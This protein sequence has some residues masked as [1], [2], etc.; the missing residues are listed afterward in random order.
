MLSLFPLPSSQEKKKIS[1]RAVSDLQ[2]HRVI[3][4]LYAFP[5][6]LTALQWGRVAAAYFQIGGCRETFHGSRIADLDI[7][8]GETG[9]VEIGTADGAFLIALWKK[10]HF[11][12]ICVNLVGVDFSPEMIARANAALRSEARRNPTITAEITFVLVDVRD[13]GTNTAAG[14]AAKTQIMRAAPNGIST[15]VCYDVFALENREQYETYRA[16]LLRLVNVGGRVVWG[17][18]IPQQTY[19]MYLRT[20]PDNTS[21]VLNIVNLGSKALVNDYL[22][23]WRRAARQNH[24]P[25]PVLEW[26][27]MKKHFAE[28]THSTLPSNACMINSRTAVTAD[29]TVVYISSTPL[30]FRDYNAQYFQYFARRAATQAF[31]GVLESLGWLMQDPNAIYCRPDTLSSSGWVRLNAMFGPDESDISLRIHDSMS[32]YEWLKTLNPRLLAGANDGL[33]LSPTIVITWKR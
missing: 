13:L 31:G 16:N 10:L 15:I 22:V 26:K 28:N 4:A 27:S 18:G 33:T 25:M 20:E 1:G 19:R 2:N 24:D 29:G 17:S 9:V 7:G 5:R 6:P 23:P 32:F 3:A 8:A 14:R 11:Q 21:T 12:G 30:R